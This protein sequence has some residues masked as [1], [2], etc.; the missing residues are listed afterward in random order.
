MWFLNVYVCVLCLVCVLSFTVFCVCVW[1]PEFSFLFCGLYVCVGESVVCF[2]WMCVCY[3]LWFVG[4]FCIGFLVCV[5]VNVYE[6][7]CGVC[8]QVCFVFM[9]E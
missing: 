8:L 6:C 1:V 2:V 5:C 7:V 9:S 4:V 3:L